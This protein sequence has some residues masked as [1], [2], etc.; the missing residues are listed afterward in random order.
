[1]AFQSYSSWRSSA[2][3]NSGSSDSRRSGSATIPSSSVCQWP[4]PRSRSRART[5]RCCTRGSRAGRPGPPPRRGSDRTWPCRCRWA[6]ASAAQPAQ[7][8]GRQRR[9]LQD[10]QHLEERMAAEIALGL[11]LLDELLEGQILMRVRAQGT[12]AHAAQQFAERGIAGDIGADS[13]RIDE[14]ADE[15]LDLGPV[16]IGDRRA[17]QMSSCRSSGRATTWKAPN[18]VM[19]SVAPSRPPSPLSAAVTVAGRSTV[20][21]APSWR[22]TGGRGRSVGNSSGRRSASWRCQ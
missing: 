17:D 3:L 22:A 10:E 8:E 14:E 18:S 15:W 5:G 19:N 13:Q 12:A 7:L 6:S 2:S 20:R 16:A 11:Q 1:M 4:Q 21:C 9:V